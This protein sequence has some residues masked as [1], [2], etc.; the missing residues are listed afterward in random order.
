LLLLLLLLLLIVVVVVV[1]IVVVIVIVD[2][3]WVGFVG[4]DLEP[5]VTVVT[6][7]RADRAGL[8]VV[9]AGAD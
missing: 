2:C 9:L 5:I 4:C 1:V 3:Y 8:T 7:V 6:I